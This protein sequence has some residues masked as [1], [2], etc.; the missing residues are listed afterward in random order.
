MQTPE[1]VLSVLLGVCPEGTVGRW[2]CDVIFGGAA[3][4]SPALLLHPCAAAPTALLHHPSVIFKKCYHTVCHGVHVRVQGEL[5]FTMWV[6]NSDSQ[7][8]GPGSC[9][10]AN[11]LFT[12]PVTTAAPFQE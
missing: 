7:P 8:V 10:A 6:H 4:L 11:Q 3:T 9:G 5:A 12:L 1:L 2:Y